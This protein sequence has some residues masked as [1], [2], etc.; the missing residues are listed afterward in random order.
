[1][2]AA[3]SKEAGMDMTNKFDG[4]MMTV[5]SPDVG[6]SYLLGR[7]FIH[8]IMCGEDK[9]FSR[10]ALDI[11]TD[12]S[13]FCKKIAFNAKNNFSLIVGINP[14]TGSLAKILHSQPI[15]V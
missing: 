4:F 10:Y 5:Y 9:K 11:I 14:L 2:L 3:R 13:Q 7:S 1:M 12:I 15:I 6:L 8:P